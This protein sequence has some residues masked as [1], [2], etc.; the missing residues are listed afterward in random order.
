MYNRRPCHA[1]GRPGGT[2]HPR[3]IL[4]SR[5]WSWLPAS[6]LCAIVLILSPPAAPAHPG[7]VTLADSTALEPF[8]LANGL[9]VVTRHG[10]R[11]QTLDVPVAYDSRR[12]DEPTGH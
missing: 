12:D 8:R 2:L 4:V 7:P 9:R 10:P 11:C 3:G 1:R 5:A 6:S